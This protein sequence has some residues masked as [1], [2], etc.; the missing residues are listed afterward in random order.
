MKLRYLPLFN[1]SFNTAYYVDGQV[2]DDIM[3]EPTSSCKRQMT[4][5]HI[6]SRSTPR[7]IALYYEGSPLT[8]DAT[9]AKPVNAEEKFTFKVSVKNSDLWY[10]ADVNGWAQD[11][12][13]FLKNPLY[14]TTGD[15]SI[16]NSSLSSPVLHRPLAFVHELPLQDAASLMEIRDPAGTLIRTVAVRARDTSE[17]AGK[18]EG[19]LV[20]LKGF[21][22]GLYSLRHVKS[23]GNVDEPVYCSADHSVG[24]FA[25]VE[26]T[27]K[28]DAAWTGVNPVQQY[29]LTIT[30]RA[31]DWVYDVYIRERP[32]NTILASKL[33]IKHEPV[34]AE[35][36]RTFSVIT[37]DD[38]AGFVQFRSDVP[39]NFSQK[40]MKLR[41]VTPDLVTP[42]DVI[43]TLP[44]P[45]AHTIVKDGSDLSTKIIVN[46]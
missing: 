14:N 2:H 19:F 16:L 28:G 38:V 35:P 43:G 46:V 4:R 42:V 18:T 20:D 22:D 27:Y 34:G 24:T 26:I 31:T 8:S 6:L 33:F 21:P 41:L 32:M 23:G 11:K 15:I 17:A 12:V 3:L 5:F 44:M 39:L 45:S 36:V 37:A 30:T 29:M 13:Y 9:A 10:Y 25:I 1:I 7:G 40:P